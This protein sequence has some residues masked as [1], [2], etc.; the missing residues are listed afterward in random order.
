MIVRESTGN[1]SATGG[2][3]LASAL[4]RRAGFVLQTTPDAHWWRLLWDQGEER[5]NQMASHAAR[6]LT[7]VGYSVELDPALA[8]GPVT[9]PT[10][11]RGTRV[12]GHAVLELTDQ[13]TGSDTSEAAA[14]AVEHV[15]D[16]ADGV[17]VRL[18]EFFEVA[19]EQANAGE[20]EAGWVLEDRFTAA[21]EQL[22]QLGEDLS[23]GAV[24]LRALAPGQAVTRPDRQARA[25]LYRT[26]AV[27]HR[28]PSTG[29]P[30]G[31]A[32][33]PPPP[34]SDKRRPHR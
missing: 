1:V 26:T 27:E 23:G 33:P 4:L 29:T 6:M 20:T 10:D 15:L 7:A 19:A 8:V 32:A 11:P 25:A 13:I 22:H 31:T 17:L 30:S 3:D 18:Q 14:Q 21:A 5:E 16:P 9:T 24:T 2:D 12:F 28:S 34:A